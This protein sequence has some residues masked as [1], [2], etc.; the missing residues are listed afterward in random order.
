MTQQQVQQL[1]ALVQ[2]VLA[3][4]EQNAKDIEELRKTIELL[5]SSN[6]PINQDLFL[7]V[8]AEIKSKQPYPRSLGDWLKIH[9]GSCS[10]SEDAETTIFSQAVASW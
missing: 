4:T 3:H 10:A 6:G 2:E 1:E 5:A 8:A 7:K 9:S